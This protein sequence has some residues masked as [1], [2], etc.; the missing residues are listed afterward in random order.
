MSYQQLLTVLC[1]IEAINNKH[2]ISF[3]YHNEIDVIP[4]CPENF[5]LPCCL[6]NANAIVN[7]HD[8]NR[9]L[10]TRNKLL[11]QYFERWKKEYLKL[12]VVNGIANNVQLKVGD[13][14]MLDDDTKRM[15]W[16]M[17]RVESV[18]VGRDG[19]VRSVTLNCKG[20]VIRRG[21]HRV[22]SLEIP[23]LNEQ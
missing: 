16:P 23:F 19:K 7:H 4:L 5:L 1:E 15:F 2:P 9:Y 10:S 13:V 3:V 20:K 17:A 14:V 8:V 12:N 21:I 11:C 22:Y 6:D 18:N